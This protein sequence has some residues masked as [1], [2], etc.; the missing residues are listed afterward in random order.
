MER[1]RIELFCEFDEFVPVDALAADLLD[2]TDLEI[3][4]ISD[5]QN[6]FTQNKLA[7]EGTE[8]TEEKNK[9]LNNIQEC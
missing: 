2:F 1:L 9:R 8:D 4:P 5:S 3:L 6:L 7:T